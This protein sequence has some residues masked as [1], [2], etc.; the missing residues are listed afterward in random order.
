[1]RPSQGK[2]TGQRRTRSVQKT[3]RPIKNRAPRRG[4][5]HNKRPS[6]RSVSVQRN[7]ARGAIK[8]TNES[9]T[10]RRDVSLIIP[11]HNEASTLAKILPRL[12]T[13]SEVKEVI[14]VANACTDATVDVAARFGAKVIHLSEKLGHDTGRA[15]GAKHASGEFL[16]FLD[17]DI[18]WTRNDLRPFIGALREGADVAVNRYPLPTDRTYHHPTSVA[19]RALNLALQHPEW[20]ASSMT[21]VPH[22]MRKSALEVIGW[23]NLAIPPLAFTAAVLGGLAIKRP[24]YVNVGKR[25][26][27]R[28]RAAR[29]Y[30]VK[31]VIL[32]DHVQ[33]LA[34]LLS[35]RGVRGGF[36]DGT[37]DRSNLSQ[38]DDDWF[39]PTLSALSQSFSSIGQFRSAAVIP[40]HN[41]KQALPGVLK[42]VS[43]LKLSRVLVV[44]NG[45]NDGT[46]KLDGNDEITVW[47]FARPLG[48]DVGRSIGARAVRHYHCVLFVDGDFRISHRS[49]IPFRDAV[50]WGNTDLA[51][52]DLGRKLPLDHKRD[53]VSTMKS[54]L[55]LFLRRPDLDLTSLTAV[56]HALSQRALQT[57]PTE[58]LSVPPK[59]YVRAVL[60]G[61]EINPVH[62]VD[63]VTTNRRRP[64]LHAVQN[65]SQ[66]AQMIIGDHLEAISVLVAQRGLRGG[67]EQPRRLDVLES[68]DEP[69]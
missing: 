36:P 25:N 65:G 27:L 5:G 7:T 48:H 67:F 39:A 53:P 22:G 59:A 6:A 43:K 46:E 69:Q 13:W 3:L 4:P 12:A 33:A 50:L 31:D 58:D 35:Q 24:K 23:Q 20:A 44:E 64:L 28:S 55:N 18:A 57:I 68:L 38:S 17:G 1:M 42:E 21:T 37:R 62:Y 19:K 9:V 49:L 56:P 63:V 54:L 66:L 41:E 16:L 45:S 14:V 8:N 60:A 40:A 26:R 51:L 29:D 47:H 32:G 52:N 15:I 61:L 10:A 34:Y 11:A 30:S 2:Q